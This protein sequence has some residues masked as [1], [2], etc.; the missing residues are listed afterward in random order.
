M[1]FH[2]YT[3]INLL[4]EWLVLFKHYKCGESKQ[5][6]LKCLLH[7]I[8]LSLKGCQ[9]T[10][11]CKDFTVLS[12]KCHG[13]MAKHLKTKTSL[14]CITQWKQQLNQCNPIMFN[15]CL[16]SWKSAMTVLSTHSWVSKIWTIKHGF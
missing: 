5:A 10:L 4:K 3:S 13:G 16:G 11:T 8:L 15:T 7:Y 12:W 1:H 6:F 14:H 9:E 2:K